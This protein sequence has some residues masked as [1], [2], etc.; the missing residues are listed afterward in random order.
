M[1]ISSPYT[2]KFSS[3]DMQYRT[4]EAKIKVSS[5]K[6]EPFPIE[7]NFSYRYTFPNPAP[8][9]HLMSAANLNHLYGKRS[10]T[11]LNAKVSEAIDRSIV[12]YSPY[13]D[14]IL[15]RS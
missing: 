15:E 1:I 6:V 5:V 9:G 10:A 4:I 13:N 7:E 12:E 8:R 11:V 3:L 2:A 14:A